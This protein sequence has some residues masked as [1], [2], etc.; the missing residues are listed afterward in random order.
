MSIRTNETREDLEFIFLIL[1]Y[2]YR[3]GK[4]ASIK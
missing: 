2:C 3:Q 4:I 1:N